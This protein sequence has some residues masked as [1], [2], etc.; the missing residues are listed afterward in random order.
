MTAEPHIKKYVQ[1]TTEP[2]EA[3]IENGHGIDFRLDEPAWQ[4]IHIG[5]IIQF[6]E[7]LSGWDKKPASNARR[8]TV[9][10]TD[11]FRAASFSELMENLPEDFA[12]GANKDSVIQDLRQWWTSEKEKET[13]VL[14]WRVTVI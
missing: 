10:I 11:I 9:R 6:W 5:D 13:G 2:L 4:D 12:H 7:D 1:L 3:L 14:G 8:V